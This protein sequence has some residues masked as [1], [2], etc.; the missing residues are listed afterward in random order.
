MKR[1]VRGDNRTGQAIWALGWMGA[2]AGYSLGEF[3]L[4]HSFCRR[5]PGKRSRKTGNF[6]NDLESSDQI[7][8]KLY[9]FDLMPFF[10]RAGLDPRRV[11]PEDMLR[12][13]TI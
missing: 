6:F 5:A 13:K 3:G 7:E 1:P 11:K 9:D 10:R 12:S 8:A 4:P 2:R